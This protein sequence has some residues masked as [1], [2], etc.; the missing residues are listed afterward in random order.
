MEI[1]EAKDCGTLDMR[2]RVHCGGHRGMPGVLLRRLL[3]EITRGEEATPPALKV[4]NQP[5]I[6]LAK[7]SELHDR[8][9]HIDVKFPFLSSYIDEGKIFI[10]FVDTNRQLA[11][12]LTKS[13]GRLRFTEV[14]K[15]IGM[16]AI[17]IQD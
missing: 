17:G 5:T 6:V 15:M 10:E 3:E 1:S 8:S 16:V 11:D 9:K 12:I 2:S 7:N 13:L 14:K 4:D